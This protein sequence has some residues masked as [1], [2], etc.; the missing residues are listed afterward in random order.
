MFI[1]NTKEEQTLVTL[2][3]PHHQWQIT[4]IPL[5][6]NLQTN[7]LEIPKNFPK[8]SKEPKSEIPQKILEIN[9]S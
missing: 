7:S 6:Q 3:L 9:F 5:A 4:Y 8:S 2:P 1:L